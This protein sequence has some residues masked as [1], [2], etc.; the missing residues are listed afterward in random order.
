MLHSRKLANQFCQPQ[1]ACSSWLYF[2]A[3]GSRYVPSAL[4]GNVSFICTVGLHCELISFKVSSLQDLSYS[5]NFRY[6]APEEVTQLAGFLG[7]GGGGADDDDSSDPF[8][9]QGSTE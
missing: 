6:S 3:R 8:T 4:P 9:L 1:L 2:P 5:N 7:L